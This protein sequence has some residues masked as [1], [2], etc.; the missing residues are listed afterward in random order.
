MKK[1]RILLSGNSNLQY[2]VDAVAASGGKPTAE[3][4]PKI[5]TDYDGLILCGGNDTDPKFYHQTCHGAVNIDLPRDEVELELLGAFVA[6]KKPVLGICRGHQLI[7]IF[8]G[9]SLVQDIPAKHLHTN[10]QDLYIAHSITAEEN[11]L[12][13][14]LYGPT[15]SVNSAHHQVVDRLGSGLVATAYWND[16]YI[17][18]I[19][20]TSLPI[21]GLQ[22]H[23][24]RMCVTQKRPDTVD[25]S[26]IFDWFI[27]LCI[28]T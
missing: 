20:H 1:A 13:Y 21:T 27:G 12:L 19:E 18:A 9:G 22:W 5:S 3:Y 8:F 4:L 6:A 2:Y 10:K 25:G 24:E 16:T 14:K 23:P 17:E 7:N 15:F 26:K 11:T 28:Q